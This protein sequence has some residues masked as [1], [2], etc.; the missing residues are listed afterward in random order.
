MP[1]TSAALRLG[2]DMHV[3]L[4]PSAY[5]MKVKLPS[6]KQKGDDAKSSES[7][8]EPSK[9]SST[10]DES[11]EEDAQSLPRIRAKRSGVLTETQQ[12][13]VDSL[14]EDTYR[15]HG[16]D[17]QMLRVD[18]SQLLTNSSTLCMPAIVPLDR[19]TQKGALLVVCLANLQKLNQDSEKRMPD[20]GPSLR[21]VR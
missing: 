15:E 10:Q 5:I 3:S 13:L 4:P 2:E 18:L 14:V 19:A 21:E 8:E 6:L 16:L 12:S 20:R 1:T 7:T 11:E 17:L 9:E